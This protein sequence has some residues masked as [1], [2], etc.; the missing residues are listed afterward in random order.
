VCDRYLEMVKPTIDDDPQQ[1]A[2]LVAVLDAVLRIMHPVMP[3]VTEALWPTVSEAR[4]GDIA[5]VVL[6]SSALLAGAAWPQLD[7]SIVD[8]AAESTFTRADELIGRIRTAR[9]TQ[10]VKPKQQISVHAPRSVL[11][12][13]DS[14]DGV[15]EVLAGVSEVAD[16]AHGRPAIASPITFDGSEILL[17]GLLD[18]VDLDAERAR[19]QKVIDA[20]TKQIGGF[21]GRLGNEGFLSNAKPEVVDHTRAL[22]AEAEADLTAA[23]TALANLGDP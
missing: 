16:L 15:V 8:A 3:F 23:R 9:A 1:Q 11:D 22:L 20:K 21:H 4:C 19:L 6:P 12:L 10:G 13:I 2:V 18:E 5:G 17:S 14:V 7:E